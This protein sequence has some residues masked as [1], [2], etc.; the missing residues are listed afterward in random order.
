MNIVRKIIIVSFL[1]LNIRTFSQD[2]VYKFT[3]G[4]PKLWKKL[5]L[6]GIVNGYK[7]RYIKNAGIRIMV[8]C[9]NKNNGGCGFRVHA[10]T[11]SKIESLFF[12]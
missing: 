8:V 12:L 1:V 11:K 2:C 7:L 9:A 5:L 10:P 6:Y 3:S 4:A